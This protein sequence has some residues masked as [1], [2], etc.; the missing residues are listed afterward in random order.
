MKTLLEIVNAS[1]TYLE[2]RGVARSKREAEELIAALLGLS[3]IDI[4][5]NF[6]RPLVES[7]LALCREAIKRRGKGEPWQ[8]IVG[9]LSFAGAIIGVQSGVLI[10]RPETELLVEKV[11]VHAQGAKVLWDICTGSGCI[12]IALKKRLPDVSVLAS[13]ISEDALAQ[14]HRSA[15][16]NEV[17]ITFLQ[18]DLFVPFEGQQADII[19]CNPPYVSDDEYPHL[20]REV[21]DF[22]PSLAL[23]GGKDGLFFYEKIAATLPAHLNSGGRAFLEIGHSQGAAILKIFESDVWAARD[24][25]KDFSQQDRYLSLIKK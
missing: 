6:E 2:E 11:V 13:D 4:Y 3:R 19:V 17:N 5:L 10:P 18:G 23:L 1:A 15:L 12:A 16:R 9:H 14:A 21:R 22:E 7:E 20:Q 25:E 24:M 8:Y